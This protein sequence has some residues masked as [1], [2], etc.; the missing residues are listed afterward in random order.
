MSHPRHHYQLLRGVSCVALLWRRPEH[1]DWNVSTILIHLQAGTRELRILRQN[2][3]AGL[4]SSLWMLHRLRYVLVYESSTCDCF[5]AIGKESCTRGMFV[6]PEATAYVAPT[7]HISPYYAHIT[8][9]RTYHLIPAH[10]TLLRTYHL[11]THISPY[12]TYHLITHITPYYAH[13][14]LFP[15]ISPYSRTYHL[16]THISPYSH[17]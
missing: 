17:T 3:L 5:A 11:I 6:A 12:Y 8:L 4:S 14:T 16:I 13:I 15:H 2:L 9:L 10:I 1:H 7:T